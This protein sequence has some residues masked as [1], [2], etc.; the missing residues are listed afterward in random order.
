MQVDPVAHAVRHSPEEQRTV[1]VAPLG[2]DVL[3]PPLE[4]SIVQAP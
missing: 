2:H 1:Q 3:H 4:Q